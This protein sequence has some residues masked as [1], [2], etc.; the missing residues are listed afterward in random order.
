MPALIATCAT[1][2]SEFRVTSPFPADVLIERS[3]ASMLDP[4]DWVNPPN[5][6]SAAKVEERIPEIPSTVPSTSPPARSLTSRTSDCPKFDSAANVP[7]EFWKPISEIDPF[8]SAAR[9]L[10][11]SPVN[12]SPVVARIS[13]MAPPASRWRTCRRE[14]KVSKLSATEIFPA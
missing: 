9:L 12:K 13:S 2:F 11:V 1:P 3:P 10:T 14:L 7:I 4:G 5:V 6:S 8:A